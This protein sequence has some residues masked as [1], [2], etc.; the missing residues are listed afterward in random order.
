MA[1]SRTRS[2]PSPANDLAARAA[3][4]R[5]AAHSSQ[6]SAHPRLAMHAVR[7]RTTLAA[8]LQFARHGMRRTSPVLCTRA[9][10]TP[11][12]ARRG[13]QP[14]APGESSVRTI[15]LARAGLRRSVLARFSTSEVVWRVSAGCGPTTRDHN[16]PGTPT[17]P[18]CTGERT[19]ECGQR[20]GVL[21]RRPPG[22]P[23]LGSL[24]R[25]ADRG[26]RRRDRAWRPRRAHSVKISPG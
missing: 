18:N 7:R 2:R 20:A 21:A 24:V 1:R 8:A 22:H 9:R 26:S 12:R 17:R 4:S 6:S 23:R 11:G 10:V 3:A 14:Q 16:S 15:D 25:R 19:R 5:G 13:G